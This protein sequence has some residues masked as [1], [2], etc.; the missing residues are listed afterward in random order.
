MM[1][2]VYIWHVKGK[3]KTEKERKV[4]MATK[5]EAFYFWGHL[6]LNTHFQSSHLIPYMRFLHQNTCWSSRNVHTCWVWISNSF[7]QVL[8][9]V[10]TV[11]YCQQQGAIKVSHPHAS[12]KGDIFSYTRSLMEDTCFRPNSTPGTPELLPGSY[13]LERMSFPAQRIWAN[14]WSFHFPEK[15]KK[16]NTAGSAEM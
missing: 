1:V 9:H 3:K 16:K 7:T 4:S 13:W 6:W 11:F 8:L 10:H 2:D 15:K 14:C 5:R 12:T